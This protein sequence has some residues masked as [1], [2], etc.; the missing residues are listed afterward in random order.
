MGLF[1]SNS[2]NA[3][4]PNAEEKKTIFLA[5]PFLANN[6]PLLLPDTVMIL[7]VIVGGQLYR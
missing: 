7:E 3:T 2:Y 4:V 1:L 5:A 6:D